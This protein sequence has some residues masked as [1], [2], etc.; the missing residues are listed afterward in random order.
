MTTADEQTL[1]G[2]VEASVPVSEG[3]ALEMFIDMDRVHVFEPG[4]A[5]VNLTAKRED[6]AMA[7]AN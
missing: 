7:R 3:Q 4:E 6:E 1:V 2:R 5:G